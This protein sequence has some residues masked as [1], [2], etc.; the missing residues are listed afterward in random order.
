MVKVEYKASY[1]FKLSLW[2]WEN[3]HL[4]VAVLSLWHLRKVTGIALF[5]CPGC[6]VI[7]FNEPLGSQNVQG[8]VKFVLGKPWVTNHH[9]KQLAGGGMFSY[10]V[11]FCYNVF[12]G[13]R[14]H[15]TT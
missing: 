7:N 11:G 2:S 13:G 3:R 12:P 9:W 10:P 1:C 4:L 14:E 8:N 5:V 6:Q 15:A